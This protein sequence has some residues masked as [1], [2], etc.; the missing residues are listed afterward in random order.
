MFYSIFYLTRDRKCLSLS[1]NMNLHN[2]C[3]QYFLE[4]WIITYITHP[5]LYTLLGFGNLL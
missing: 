2:P 5:L 3:E 4:W 1:L